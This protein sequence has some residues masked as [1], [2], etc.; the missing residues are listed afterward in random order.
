LKQAKLFVKILLKPVGFTLLKVV[1]LGKLF[2]AP[3]PVK[4]LVVAHLCRSG[5]PNHPNNRAFIE[6]LRSF[7]G[8]SLRI[9]ETGTSAWGADSTRLWDQYVQYAG[10]HVKSVDIRPDPGMKLQGKLSDKSEL[11]VED[12]VEFLRSIEEKH[13]YADL[14]Y[15][16]FFGVDW[17][18][19]DSAE[20]H[21]EEE[22]KIVMRLVRAS[23]SVH[24]LL[25]ESFPLEV[26]SDQRRWLAK[27]LGISLWRRFPQSDVFVAKV[28]SPGV[29]EW[30]LKTVFSDGDIGNGVSLFADG[31]P[32]VTGTFGI[33]VFVI[34]VSTSGSMA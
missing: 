1:Q 33:V 20:I 19:P 12:S 22:F 34:K 27:V 8:S 4:M 23:Q 7:E 9:L 29:W 5:N 10:G 31:A 28:S 15:L 17:G 3:V 13:E 24:Q 26:F 11:V 30:A 21:G 2:K 6:V 16:D 32:V 25:Q 18:N 14:I